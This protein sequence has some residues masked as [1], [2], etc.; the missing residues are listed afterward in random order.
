MAEIPKMSLESTK[1]KARALLTARP[2][3]HIAVGIL[4]AVAIYGLLGFFA[5]PALIRHIAQKQISTQLDRSVTIS[6]VALNPFTLRFEAD[7]VHIA[8][9]I[10]AAA[11]FVTIQRLVVRPSWS[12]LFHLAPI[13]KEVQIDSPDVS[14]VRYDAEHFN[15]SDLIAKFSKPAAA[16]SNGKPAR[17][18]VSNIHIDNGRIHFDDRLLHAQHIVDHFSLGIPFVATLASATDIFVTPQLQARIDG[19][20]LSVVGRTKPFSQSK[21]SDILLKLDGLDLPRLTSYLPASVP[22]LVKS[23][24]LST[25]LDVRFS[26]NGDAPT[27]HI[28]GTADLLGFAASDHADVPVASFHALHVAV[29][30]AEPLRSVYAL[31][32]IRLSGPSVFLSRDAKGVLNLQKLMTPAATP[33]IHAASATSSST[34]ASAPSSVSSVAPSAPAA[35][36][37][38]ASSSTSTSTSATPVN[39]STP[40]TTPLDVLIKHLS[41]E[42]GT[43]ALNDA[44][45]SPRTTLG[46]SKL[47]VTVDSFSTLA[48]TPASYDV[49]TVID[50]GGS[51]AVSG[52]V[53]LPAKQTHVKLAVDSFDLPPLQPYLPNTIAAK[54]TAGKLSV[55]LPIDIDWSA[56]QVAVN[57]GA[58]SLNLHTLTLT[59]NDA[60][61]PISLTSAVA[62]IRKIDVNAHTAVLD[63][64]QIT[65]LSLA[66]KRLKDG[67]V[68]FSTLA[69]RATPQAP[70]DSRTVVPPA[71]SATLA[72]PATSAALAQAP[73]APWHYQIGQISLSEANADFTDQ[74]T[75]HPVNVRVSPLA[76][77]VASVSDDLHKPLSVSAQ[78]TLNGSG[79]V[80]VH[81]VVTPDPLNIALHVDSKQ[82]DVRPFEP[83]FGDALNVSMASAAL[84][85]N[86][87]VNAT[88]GSAADAQNAKHTKSDAL[89]LSYNGDVSLTNVRM[90]D[91]ASGDAVAGWKLLGA[92][93]LKLA[94]NAHGTNVDVAKITFARFYG[95]VLLDA[96][97][98]LNL[99]DVVATK[100]ASG[101]AA[102]VGAKAS[103]ETN[104]VPIKTASNAP[105][106]AQHPTVLRVGQVVL[107]DGRVT[108]SDNFVRPNYTANL[109]AINGTIGAFGTHSTSP[110]PVDVAASLSGNGPVSIKGTV[111][112]LLEKPAL[113]LTASAHDVELTDLTPYSSKYVGYPITKGKLNV[114]LH[115]ALADN[116]LSANN[117]LF[118]D[119]LTF[120]DRVDAPG[121]T[122]LPVRLAVSLLKNS[123]GEIDVNIPVSGSLSNPEFS[124]GSVVWHAIL[125]LV[126]RAVTAPFSLLTHAFGGGADASA[127]QYV[128]FEPGSA[129]LTTAAQK[130][131]DAIGSALASKPT[132]QLALTAHVDPRVDAPAL[133]TASLEN[134]VKL[135]KLKDTGGHSVGATADLSGVTVEANE[136][137]KYLTAAYKAADFKKPRNFIGMTKTLPADE[138]EKAL[139]ENAPVDSAALKTLAQQRASAVESYLGKQIDVKRISIAPANAT[140]SSSALEGSVASVASVAPASSVSSA[141]PASPASA[142]LPSSSA[143]ES[144]AGVQRAGGADNNASTRVDFTLK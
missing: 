46:L 136:Y 127:L 4:I 86:G 104:A 133:R 77:T 33:D 105:A 122:H 11:N 69:G 63:N 48:K 20:L 17:F 92:N 72:T 117:H 113:D 70:A 40:S 142:A 102:G 124:I 18:A 74:S 78:L 58:G 9:K 7:G 79:N 90:V 16:P 97:G 144:S 45:I 66:A 64:V 107:E 35:V 80:S 82:L 115:Y 21:D 12:S 49:K 15:F 128:A 108:Y 47:A 98:K 56:P 132:I 100:P 131:L 1:Q 67:S 8:D 139:S 95:R 111:N 121:V 41:I 51:L 143:R 14:I 61:A 10:D 22:L 89:A 43:V 42:D 141:S 34:P 29:A 125:N 118:I 27:I 54:L 26:I 38:S 19:S 120:G 81:G 28:S 109:L 37:A 32:E 62:N 6:R 137:D 44:S 84:N 126:E 134:Q 55:A 3:R 94:Y 129:V 30:D 13:I 75:P 39:V 76:L 24:K 23:G 106:Q 99:R 130:K 57:V 103:A 25:D 101:K 5:A 138:M 88:I 112:P 59:P 71:A 2:T 93:G 119:Q 110:A 114:D 96:Q 140:S 50:H 135:A 87:D 68:D 91:K 36:T 52:T 83:Y 85:V 60:A 31:D 53:S 65:G 123:R 73:A 116:N